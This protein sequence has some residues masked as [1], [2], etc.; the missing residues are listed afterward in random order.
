RLAAARRWGRE[1]MD[2]SD[3]HVVEPAG[4]RC[5]EMKVLALAR[6]IREREKAQQMLGR[7]IELRSRNAAARKRQV[8]DGIHDCEAE[9]RKITVPL[10]DSWYRGI[11][12]VRI[13]RM[14]PRIVDEKKCAR[15][16]DDF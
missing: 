6:L 11:G 14:I 9:S 7:G 4:R 10:G 12:V 16:V 3:V 13:A 1:G 15:A 2:D 5:H 8:R